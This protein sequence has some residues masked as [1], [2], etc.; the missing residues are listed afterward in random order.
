MIWLIFEENKHYFSGRVSRNGCSG[1]ALVHDESNK[2][3]LNLYPFPY[4]I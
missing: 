1:E 4:F 2:G 3:D